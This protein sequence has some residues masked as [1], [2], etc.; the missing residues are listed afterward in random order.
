M[1]RYIIIFGILILS[2][3][4]VGQVSEIVPMNS[5]RFEHPGTGVYFKDIDNELDY[6]VGTWE[7]VQNNKKY[8]FNFVK[9]TQQ[10]VS[11]INDVNYFKDVIKVKFK[12]VDLTN[13][14]V[15]YDDTATTDFNDYK[16]SGISLRSSTFRFSFL[17]NENCY[18]QINFDI[19]KIVNQP[20]VL[21]YCYFSYF[22]Y[23]DINCPFQNQGDIPM[24]L[25]KQ[26][27]MLTKV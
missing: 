1:K 10:L 7:G 2:T 5:L 17:D 11:D 25:P 12:V 24:Y 21:R 18:N 20:N 6:F 14:Q 22:E 13:N 4:V 15:L 3:K 19:H 8:T 27:L 9:F 23:R 16:I 26:D